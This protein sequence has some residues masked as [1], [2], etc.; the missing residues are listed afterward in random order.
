MATATS[1]LRVIINTI[2]KGSP[3]LT[4]LQNDLARV[5]VALG[6]LATAGAIAKQAFDFAEEGARINL[7][8]QQSTTFAKS[9]GLN[10]D[11]IIDSIKEAS[12]YTVSEMDAMLIAN[13]ALALGVTASTDDFAKL[14]TIAMERAPL[15]GMSV[16]QAFEDIVTGIGRRSPLILDNLGLVIEKGKEY[17][18]ASALM[19][20]VVA[21]NFDRAQAAT[22]DMAS[23]SATQFDQL[24][25]T[26]Q[27]LKAEFAAGFEEG[28]PAGEMLADI[29]ENLRAL[30]DQMELANEAQRLLTE[31]HA[32][33]ADQALIMAKGLRHYNEG[34]GAASTAMDQASGRSSVFEDRSRAVAAQLRAEA[35]A[36]R[37]AKAAWDALYDARAESGQG[38]QHGGPVAAGQ[39]YIVGEAGPELFVPRQSGQIVPNQQ[40][41]NLNM[42]GVSINNGMDQMAFEEMLRSIGG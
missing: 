7:L 27:D 14:M 39:S 28:T 23:A 2:T 17:A 37:E 3:K 15:M 29:N 6:A 20:D 5:G 34:L 35:R 33:N 38:R 10:M 13:K 21:A 41:T 40:V 22:V 4:G 11:N 25:A 1:N 19:A 42:G 24:K 12:Y 9:F 32:E 16:T 8:K 31:G 30:K 36:A 26:W 18:D